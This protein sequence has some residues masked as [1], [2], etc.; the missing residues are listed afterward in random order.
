MNR[1]LFILI[2][3]F[4]IGSCTFTGNKNTQSNNPLLSERDTPFDVPPFDRIETSHFIPAFEQGMQEQNELIDEIINNPESPDFDNT[5]AAFAYSSETLE[6]VSDVFYGL[7]SAATNDS[8]QAIAKQ[9]SPK[10]SSHKDAINLNPQLF[11]RI[12]IVYDKADKEQLTDEQLFILE[13]LYRGFVRSGATLPDDKKGR[14]MEINKELS[15][16]GLQFRENV[17]KET[18]SYQLIIDNEKDLE[19][20]PASVIETAAEK[21]KEEGMEGKW[22]FTTQKPSMIPFLQYADNRELRKEIYMAYTNL[23][24]HDNELDNKKVLSDMVKLRAE[25]AKLLGY[26]NHAAYRLESRM[27]KTP[28]NA[29]D[30]LE[31]LWDA[32]VPVAKKE[33]AALQ[34]IAAKDIPEIKLESWDWWYYAEKLRKEKYDLDESELR[35]YFSVDQVR[36]GA[37]G[38]ANKLFGLTFT[39][40]K[41]IPKPHPDAQAYQVK[42]QNGDHIGILYM[43]FFPRESKRG[44]AWCGDYQDYMIKN[45][46][47]VPPVITVVGNF[48]EP[49]ET[50]PSLLSMD[51]TE[52][53]FHEFG[54]ALD[55]LL[56]RTTYPISYI[57]WDFVELPSQI[58]EHW[59]FQPEVLASYA[60][61]YQTGEVIP[62]ELIQKISESKL[63]NQG[64]AT[65]EYLAAARLDM[66]YHT[67]SEPGNIDVAN[68][69]KKYFDKIGLIPEIVSRYRS[70]YFNHI[71][72]GYDAG[73]Y[74]YIW[75]SVMDNDAFEAFKE[76]SLFDQA[77]ARSFRKNILEKN[78]IKEP[79]QMYI[80][81]R[82]R[83]PEI[84]PLLRSRGL[85]MN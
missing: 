24:N 20:L 13:N 82:G 63:F 59:A 73:Y 1:V 15:L 7:L 85:K 16:L 54:H 56:A 65:M 49:T 57:A 29:M 77:T 61:H 28:E 32:T 38:V 70:T 58:M 44:G 26:E 10:L 62:D 23:A 69:E 9:L 50:T 40:I 18:N 27:A 68:F 43:D 4:I 84:E 37:F 35:P 81:F 83:E 45:E 47:P 34:E 74:V 6:R 42:E 22:I 79:M 36:E 52:T 21:A 3:T 39:E 19:G 11:E 12:E 75:A 66:A 41:D 46:E 78:G 33:A 80:D 48:T 60:K 2:I 67:L 64:F 53:L 25:R 31:N 51:E 30:L 8:M 17:L 76:T 14:L 5:V 55:G 71:S 72:G